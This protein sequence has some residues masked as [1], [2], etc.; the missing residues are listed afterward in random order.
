MPSGQRHPCGGS[1]RDGQLLPARREKRRSPAITPTVRCDLKC[2]LADC[3]FRHVPRES[4]D[5]VELCGRTVVE[6]WAKGVL[7]VASSGPRPVASSSG[8]TVALE[9]PSSGP[10][11]IASSSGR[12]NVRCAPRT[13]PTPP[14]ARRADCPGISVSVSPADR[15]VQETPREPRRRGSNPPRSGGSSRLLQRLRRACPRDRRRRIC[16]PARAPR[17]S[18]R[19]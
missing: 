15:G 2:V 9:V 7:E 17:R 4:N 13:I 12:T 18:R 14:A 19:R 11:A 5:E 10:R 6:R 8:R 1:E 16:P 3:S